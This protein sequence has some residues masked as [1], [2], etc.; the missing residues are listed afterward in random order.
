MTVKVISEQEIVQEATEVLLEHLSP[1]KMA[2]FW[3]AW[4]I[5]KG[6]YLAIRE[7]LFAEETVETL[8]EKVRVYQE[9]E[10]KAR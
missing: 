4:Q 6:D 1:A 3:A 9:R 10:D 8:F 2:R 5:G 7:R